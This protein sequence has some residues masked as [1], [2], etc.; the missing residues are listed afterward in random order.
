MEQIIVS[1]LAIGALYW[2]VRVIPWKTVKARVRVA[3]GASLRRIP[4]RR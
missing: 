4:T 2:G 3:Q 1:A